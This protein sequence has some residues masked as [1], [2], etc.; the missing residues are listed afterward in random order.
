MVRPV[1]IMAP[2]FILFRCIP[3]GVVITVNSEA[4]AQTEAVPE[5]SVHPF[6]H[7]SKHPCILTH[8][9]IYIWSPP[10][11]QVVFQPLNQLLQHPQA[12]ITGV[13]HHIP[14]FPIWNE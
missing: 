5:Y 13:G 7:P 8:L 11:A 10:I 1:T 12:R 6:I 14:P 9:S 4:Q 2:S 3:A